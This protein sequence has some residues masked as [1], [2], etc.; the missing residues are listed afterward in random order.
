MALWS[1]DSGQSVDHVLAE[2]VPSVAPLCK[3]RNTS[4]LNEN[5]I[6]VRDLAYNSQYAVSVCACVRVLHI[7]VSCC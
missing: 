2:S 4:A 7:T 3:F 1:I 6:K 5:G